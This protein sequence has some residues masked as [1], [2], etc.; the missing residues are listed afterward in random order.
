M[1]ENNADSTVFHRVSCCRC[2]TW[3]ASATFSFSR[4]SSTASRIADAVS[5]CKWRGIC[6]H[7]MFL[8]VR[9][10]DGPAHRE[11]VLLLIVGRTSC[12]LS[13]SLR[14]DASAAAAACSEAELLGCSLSAADSPGAV[15]ANAQ[16]NAPHASS[17][18]FF[19][20][21][22]DAASLQGKLQDVPSDFD[23]RSAAGKRIRTQ[24]RGGTS[25][26]LV[27]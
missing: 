7:Y 15:A 4:S 24:T 9:A 22:C 1:A 2:Y 12:F 3:S 6:M 19:S 21:D 27:A 11:A 18:A 25:V 20:A 23:L 13:W 8:L 5:S 17:A 14:A 26:S 16:Q 10:M